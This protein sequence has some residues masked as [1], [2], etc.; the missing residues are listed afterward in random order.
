[1]KKLKIIILAIFAYAVTFFINKDMAIMSLNNSLGFLIEMFKVLPPV[2]VLTGLLS[3]WVPTR[4]IEDNL[5]TKS[6]IKGTVFSILMGAFSSGPIYAAFPAVTVL[7][8]K[9]ASIKNSVIILSSW[10]VIKIP[11]LFV[12]SSFLG[13]NFALKRYIITLPLIIFI[14]IIMDKLIKKEKIIPDDNTLTLPKLNCGGCGF[15]SCNDFKE[16]L[17]SGFSEIKDCIV[18]K[19][20]N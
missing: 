3:V 10:A 20:T 18:L 15:K 4:V 17:D 13:F 12:E 7:L 11:M 8:K 5:G 9:G 2:M 16:S 19:S 6:G 14:G 1:M